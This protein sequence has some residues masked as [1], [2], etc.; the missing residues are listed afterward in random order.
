MNHEFERIE[1][2]YHSGMGSNPHRY[3]PGREIRRLCSPIFN[4]GDL[5]GELAAFTWIEKEARKFGLT[6]KEV[7]RRRRR[8]VSCITDFK[9][10]KSLTE[11]AT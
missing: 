11:T 10:T 1:I 2:T 6:W 9:V 4:R 3:T 8:P 7:I 5:P